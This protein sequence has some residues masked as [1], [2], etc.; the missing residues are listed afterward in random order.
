[1]T[2]PNTG[3]ELYHFACIKNNHSSS[4]LFAASIA[5]D[6]SDS[7]D[8]PSSQKTTSSSL[9]ANNF[10]LIVPVPNH[11]RIYVL[12]LLVA[13][14]SAIDFRMQLRLQKVLI[15]T[16][17]CKIFKKVGV[18][19]GRNVPISLYPSILSIIYK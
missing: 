1:M 8:S 6:S 15:F 18:E 10:T 14:G 17:I 3:D 2:L 19:N 4:R 9:T 7:S 16:Y 12:S 11:S 5:A 13:E